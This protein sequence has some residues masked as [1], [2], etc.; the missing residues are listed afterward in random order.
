MNFCISTRRWLAWLAIAAM[1][2]AALAPAMARALEAPHGA[3]GPDVAEICTVAGLRQIAASE[4]PSSPAKSMLHLSH[5]PFCHLE[6]HSPAILPDMPVPLAA[7]AGT[8]IRPPLF[9]HAPRVLP[10][11][12]VAQPRAPPALLT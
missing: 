4:A 3:S 8:A 11:W 5:C 10:A 9:F 1:L 2:M 12:I 7:V 6:A